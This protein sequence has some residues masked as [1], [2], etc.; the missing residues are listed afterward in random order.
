MNPL[1]D[2]IDPTPHHHFSTRP[3]P[4]RGGTGIAPERGG[5]GIARAVSLGLLAL[6]C[7]LG[8]ESR[9]GEVRWL[10]GEL[11]GAALFNE[12]QGGELELSFLLPATDGGDILLVARGWRKGDLGRLEVT[13]PKA[14]PARPV[15]TLDLVFG[16]C[17]AD[18]LLRLDLRALAKAEHGG[19]GN[20]GDGDDDPNAWCGEPV[21]K[22]EHGGTGTPPAPPGGKRGRGL[23]L[24]VALP[25]ADA[26]CGS[27]PAL[28]AR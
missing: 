26:G 1:R 13:H 11:G 5:T 20:D 9:A 19:T 8:T 2:R 15:G 22:A 16:A 17:G 4:E 28:A 12:R 24:V 10:G 25:S 27:S 23:E 21:A 14:G 18:G 7:A 3:S 6:G